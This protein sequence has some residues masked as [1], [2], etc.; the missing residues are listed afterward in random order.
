LGIELKE[1][2]IT[3]E[4]LIRY[5]LGLLSEQEQER[6]EERMFSDRE[7]FDRL[8]VVEDDLIDAYAGGRLS[9]D[10]SERFE[11]YFLQ[12]IGDRERVGFARELAAVVTRGARAEKPGSRFKRLAAWREVIRNRLVLI[13]VTSTI[14]LALAGSWL[15]LE[16]SRLNARLAEMR[17]EQAGKER[18]VQE[19]EQQITE[20]RRRSRELLEEI[21]RERAGREIED[22]A[23]PEPQSSTPGFL[24]FILRL[25]AVRDRSATTSLS[26]PNDAK[27][28]RLDALFKTGD[29]QSYRAELQTVEGRALWQR[30]GLRQRKRGGDKSVSLSLPANVLSEGDYILIL[31]GI[32]TAGEEASVGEYYFR[33]TRK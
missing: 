7:F 33:V 28:V 19:L 21:E 4:L 31:S 18:E 32:T 17:G 25:D 1:E 10:E 2:S 16:T 11:K 14:L 30:D 27:Q 26:I 22:R 6:V 24:S 29:Y 3:D 15:L 9:R 23:R 20:E 5:A 8:L 13:P 12:T